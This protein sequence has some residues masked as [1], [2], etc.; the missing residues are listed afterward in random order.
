[1]ASP[2]PPFDP[3]YYRRYRSRSI[4]GP[5]VL[6]AIGIAFLLGNMHV[7]S[8]GQ[9]AWMF[10]TW[11]P[12]LLILL[13]VIRIVEYTVARSQG[14]PAPRFG[15]GGVV[16][17]VLFIVIGLS[18]SSARHWN[19]QAMGDNI[20]VNPGW[21]GVFGQKY[22]FTQ[23]VSQ[24]L[25][26]DG[27]I[28]I[29]SDHGSV[30]VHVTDNGDAPVKLVVHRHI[31][32]ESQSEADKYN[33]RQNAT[34]TA[35]GNTLR[36]NSGENQAH[37]QV[38][39]VMGPR[40]VSDMEVWAPRKAPVQITAAHGDINVTQRDA[41]VKVSTTHGDIQVS[42]I[43]GNVEATSHKGD[44]QISQITGDVHLDGKADDVTLSDI[45]GIAVLDGEFFGDTKLSHIGKYVRFHST[46]TEM[47][48][49][50]LDGDLSMDSGDLHV[51]SVSGPFEVHTRAKDIRLEDISGPITIENSHGEIDLHPKAPYGDVNVSNHQGAIHVVLPENAGFKVDARS[52]RG[53]L[54][55]DF[56]LNVTRTGEDRVAEGTVGKGGNKLQLTTDHGTIEIRKG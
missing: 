7:I 32:A 8:P 14:G 12:L 39:F 4:S 49:G 18:A 54:E 42:Q 37:V 26:A 52:S 10:A 55:S 3:R 20:D 38:G 47:E 44:I 34:I 56:A 15:G 16:L 9:I 21:D 48:L 36:I 53:E 43:K 45:S 1:V 46:R 35:D 13:G 33:A 23:E 17:L 2:Q 51:T 30:T 50:K 5:I 19:W 25:P 41:D 24:A 22:D 28:Q 6:V 29:D 11:W 40:L 31:A 27:H